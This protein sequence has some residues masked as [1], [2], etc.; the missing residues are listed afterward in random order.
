MRLTLVLLVVMLVLPGCITTKMNSEFMETTT[1]FNEDSGAVTH[2]TQTVWEQTAKGG[3]F[4]NI[5]TLQQDTRYVYDGPEGEH[6]DIGQGAGATGVDGTGQVQAFFASMA[7]I[8]ALA[9]QAGVIFA[10][11][12]IITDLVAEPVPNTEDLDE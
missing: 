6:Y 5:E 7:A 3:P 10:P 11:Q 2:E 9:E 1:Y 4:T 8:Q 12:T